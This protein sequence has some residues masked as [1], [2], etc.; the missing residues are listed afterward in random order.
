MLEFFLQSSTLAKV[1]FS[2]SQKKNSGMPFPKKYKIFFPFGDKSFN[3]N[4]SNWEVLKFEQR[5]ESPATLGH[6]FVVR[7]LN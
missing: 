4:I 2:K 1:S 3:M 6:R 5:I 7:N